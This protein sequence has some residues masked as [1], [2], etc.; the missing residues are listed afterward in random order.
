MNM[1]KLVLVEVVGSVEDKRCFFTLTFMKS[2]LQNKLITHL[3]LVEH[4]IFAQCFYMVQNFLHE[5]CI[6][7]WKYVHHYYWH[8][9]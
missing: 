5:E 6:E 9:G 2:K 4:N 8:D 7:W 3:P 1:V